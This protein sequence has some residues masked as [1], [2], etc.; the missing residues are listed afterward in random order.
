MPAFDS[1]ADYYAIFSES[2]ARLEREGPLLAALLGR[3]RGGRVVDLA[4]GTGLHAAYLASLSAQVTACDISPEMIAYARAHHPHPSIEYI[5]ADMRRLPSGPWDLAI[6]LGNSLSLLRDKE[7]IL[8][9]CEAIGASLTP[10]GLFLIQLLNYEADDAR[11]PRHRVE[12]KHLDGG[13]VIA[14]KSLAPRG[15]ETLLSATFH[16]LDGGNWRHISEATVLQ[17]WTL[18]AVADAAMDAGMA[19]HE[20]FGDYGQS[21]FDAASSPDLLCLLERST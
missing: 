6:C 11:K 15:G 1:I 12:R 9:V 5:V 10:G 21:P 3:V 13:E 4:C 17:H 14:V 19:V 8:R 18:D 20:V 7:D 2:E 16:V